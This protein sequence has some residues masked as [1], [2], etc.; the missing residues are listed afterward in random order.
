[1]FGASFI[2]QRDNGREFANKITQNLAEM[3]PGMKLVHGKPRHSQS[4]GSVERSNKDV[5]D[6]LVTWM[7]D[8]MK[9]WSE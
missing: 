8:N 3:W 7:S 2:L 6:M 9:T 5:Q 1:M 4:Q